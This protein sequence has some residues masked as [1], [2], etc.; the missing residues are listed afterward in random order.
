MG[1]LEPILRPRE[2]ARSVSLTFPRCA[3][4]EN[5]PIT[6]PVLTSQAPSAPISDAAFHNSLE[7][8]RASCDPLSGLTRSPVPESGHVRDAYRV[9]AALEQLPPA[10]PSRHATGYLLRL[11]LL[12]QQPPR[13]ASTMTAARK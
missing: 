3:A 11:L 12:A 5:I 2:L 4:G 6:A 10:S 9:S 1:L 8:S 7:V 13:G